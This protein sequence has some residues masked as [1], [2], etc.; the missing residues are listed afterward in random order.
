M[1]I[2]CHLQQRRTEER[3]LGEVKRSSC[4]FL[5]DFASPFVLG[6]QQINEIDNSQLGHV[7]R[8]KHL[9]CFTIHRVE[10]GSQAFVTS[11]HL[12]QT[13]LQGSNYKLP[14]HTQQQ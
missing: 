2:C 1:V 9:D 7:R 11:Q 3:P 5:D 8:K 12:C 4:L 10:D 6:L 14:P 13:F